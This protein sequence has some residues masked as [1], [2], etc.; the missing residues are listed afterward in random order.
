[1][2]GVHA[3]F[4]ALAAAAPQTGGQ[5]LDGMIHSCWPNLSQL[6]AML[7]ASSSRHALGIGVGTVFANIRN[8]DCYTFNQLSFASVESAESHFF[9]F[10]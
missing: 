4:S 7:T 6:F 10:H 3:N 5:L 9:T 2:F 1:V 8:R